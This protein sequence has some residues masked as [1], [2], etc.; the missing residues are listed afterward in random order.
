MRL[1]APPKPA[2]VVRSAV[3]RAPPPKGVTPLHLGGLKTGAS[4]ES[5]IKEVPEEEL[6]DRGGSDERMRER[7]REVCI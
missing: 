5:K 7:V 6:R 3:S 4:W 2:G 1:K